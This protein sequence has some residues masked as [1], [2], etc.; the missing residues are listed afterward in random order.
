MT[1][2][3]SISRVP[4]THH[5]SRQIRVIAVVSS[6]LALIVFLAAILTFSSANRLM[7][8]PAKPLDTFSSNI[9]PSFE[10]ASF[11]SLDEQTMLSGWFFTT[12]S[13]PLST[14]ILVHDQGE[15]RLQ[16]GLDSAGLYRFLVGLGYNVLAFDL[17]NSGRSE[18]EMSGYG[19]AEWED[20]LAAI[21]YVRKNSVTTNVLLYGF[22]TGVTAS[23]LAMDELPPA[24][25]LAGE[26]AEKVLADYAKPI[27]KLGFDQ[28]YIRGMLL[29][30]PCQSADDYIRPVLRQEGFLGNALLQHTVP[31]AIRLSAGNTGRSSLITILTRCQLPVF[32]TYSTKDSFVG[33]PVIAPLIRERQRLH[34]DTTIVFTTS[35]KG[36]AEGYLQ[37]QA[38]YKA[39][40]E[41]FL[42]RFFS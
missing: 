14:I 10:L 18:G 19:Y 38:A 33:E 41:G 12:E 27:Q 23:L 2:K 32:L 25:T 28:S 42:A 11:P 1:A 5:R 37:D 9:L 16:F 17:R 20:V 4:A 40:V 31:Y 24:G 13:T 8:Q 3:S 35:E 7:R 34:P 30:T 36:Y 39:A 21:S 6:L 29:D 22:G 15:N 26:Q